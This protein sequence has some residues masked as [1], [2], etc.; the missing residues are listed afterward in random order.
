MRALV[1]C[2]AVLLAGCAS[3]N[4]ARECAGISRDYINENGGDANDCP[5]GP[6]IERPTLR[7]LVNLSPP[8]QKAVVSVYSFSDLTG[9]R[10]TADNMALFS[11]AVTQGADSFLIDALL[12]AGGGTWFLVA[13]RGNL[14]ALTRER[15]LIISTRNS[16]DGEGANKLAPLLFSGLILTGGIIGYDAN[17]R[18]AGIGAR[19]LGIGLNTQYR[20]D[21]V[22]V[23]LRVVL[24]Q[25]GQV[26]LNVI[27]SKRVYSASTGFDTFIF[28]ENG[29]ELVELE[30]GIARNETATYAT[31]SAIEA[32]VYAIIIKGIEDDLWDYKPQQEASNAIPPN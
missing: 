29:T 21:E 11:T 5:R 14:D 9:Q 26:L 25:T 19:F 23:A 15:Q 20:V 24:V 27:T 17:T 10:A 22:T 18:S 31:R 7:D 30:A 2:F 8:R 12:A 1:L 13:E 4:S 6:R 3:V 28:T 32:A 16:Y